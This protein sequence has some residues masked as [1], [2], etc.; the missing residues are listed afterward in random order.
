M[1]PL[2][3]LHFQ[4]QLE[5]VVVVDERLTRDAQAAEIPEP[6]LVMVARLTT[7]EVVAY[8]HE[9][10]ESSLQKKLAA[11][12][13]RLQFPNADALLDVLKKN[14]L[15]A[16][17]TH[18]LTYVFPP[19]SANA[20]DRMVLRYPKL[21]PRIQAFGFNGF[22][23]YVY[24]I[25]QSGQ[26]ISACVSARENELCGEAWVQTRPSYQR[27]GLACKV[28]NAW[29]KSLMAM[30]KIP[31][32]SHRADNEASAGL[33]KRLGLEPI[34]EEIKISSAQN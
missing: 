34:F 29:A 14:D 31:F 17:S 32:Y 1:H 23:D 2:T 9:S 3:Y 5:G 11:C 16:E 21:D 19:S 33:A 6:P 30:G 24:G 7:Q 27:Q 18:Y 15:Q 12:V 20:T 8:Y 10:I 28:V 26:V 4:L 22:S 13:Q 25:E